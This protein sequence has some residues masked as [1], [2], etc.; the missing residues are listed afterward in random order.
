MK[1][2][3]P[4]LVTLNIG[5]DI[6]DYADSERN[7][8]EALTREYNISDRQLSRY[9]QELRHLGMDI[10]SRRENGRFTWHCT[11]AKDIRKSG[12]LY[13]WIELEEKRSLTR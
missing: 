13:A 5:W 3:N 9:I 10:E 7:T 12:R 6:L 8:T 2:E 4:H 11:N 1:N